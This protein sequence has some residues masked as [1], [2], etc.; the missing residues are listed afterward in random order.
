MDYIVEMKNI[1]KDFSGVKALQDVSFQLKP[2]EVHILL[3]EN[4]AGKSTLMKILSGVYEPSSGS[5]VINGTAFSKLSPKESVDS[6]ISVIYQELSMIDELS[7]AENIFVGKLPMIKK[8]GIPV[9]DFKNMEEIAQRMI[10]KVGLKRSSKDLVERLSISEKQQVEI[11]KAI[12]SRA[13]VIVMD[14]PTS[15]LTGEETNK[16]FG[17]IRQLKYLGVGIIYISHKL[18]ELLE[19]G[20]RVSVLKDGKYVGTKDIKDVT[21]ET[22]V[23]M[24]VGR[25]VNE[26]HLKPEDS[27]H[28]G[29]ETLLKVEGLTRKDRMVQDVSFELKKGEI[30]G[31]SGL[32]GSGRTEL[33]NAIYGAAPIAE[34]RIELFGQEVII[35]SP[36]HAIKLGIGH[37]TESRKETGFLKNFEIWKNISLSRLLKTSSLG[38]TWGLINEKQEKKW[39]EEYKASINIKCA[40]IEQNIGELSGGNQQKVLIG[41]WLAAGSKLMIFD[42]PTKGIDIGARGEIYKIMREL[43]EDGVGVMVVSSDLPELLSVCDRIIVFREGRMN[44][45]LSIEEATEENIMLAATS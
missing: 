24:M 25:A 16:L 43:A 19:I 41:K 3:G 32:I 20:D 35:K 27:I 28:T 22:L 42:E 40:S 37:V 9:V 44:G 13:K 6:G 5:I 11:A 1:S 29:E 7:I 30:L 18:H 38:G 21:K 17:I 12:A 39:A 15:S 36:Y 2:G 45:T 33:M 10:E 26:R 8:F 34:G 31:F 14:E 23:T 4:G